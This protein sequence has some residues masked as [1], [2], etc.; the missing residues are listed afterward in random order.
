MYLADGSLS[1]AFLA[2]LSPEALATTAMRA[3]GMCGRGVVRSETAHRMAAL[4]VTESLFVETSAYRRAQYQ[5]KKAARQ[6]LNNPQ[7][8]WSGRSTTR[9]DRVTRIA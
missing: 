3:L 1:Q 7:A 9:G 8:D 5:W 6:L 2:T 4:A